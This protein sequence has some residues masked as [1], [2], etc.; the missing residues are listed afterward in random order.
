MSVHGK[1]N[2]RDKVRQKDFSTQEIY[3][4]ISY[5]I[6]KYPIEYWKSYVISSLHSH[7]GAYLQTWIDRDYAPTKA[8]NIYIVSLL[9]TV[10][11]EQLRC[12]NQ[13]KKFTTN[14]SCKLSVTPDMLSAVAEHQSL[15]P[16]II[17]GSKCLPQP[18]VL[19]V[20]I[21]KFVSQ[22]VDKESGCVWNSGTP[23][24]HVLSDSY[25]TISLPTAMSSWWKT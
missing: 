23:A 21:E 24:S 9:P 13:V 4:Q 1:A 20:A 25:S 12:L 5:G 22:M 14:Y 11:R 10:G 2:E 3:P 15:W 8:I 18:R 7:Y 17:K 19:V 6:L 16:A